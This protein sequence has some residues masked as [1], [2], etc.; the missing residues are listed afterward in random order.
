MTN[1]PQSF[2]E[3]RKKISELPLSPFALKV[4]GLAEDKKARVQ[5]LAEAISR[6][7]EFAARL[8]RIL[9]FAPNWPR[10]LST[11]AQA[12]TVLGSDT[13]KS[14]AFGLSLYPFAPAPQD[15]QHFGADE[16]FLLALRPLW[17][18]SLGCAVVAG[19][20]AAK[21]DHRIQGLAFT[22]G[23]LH[24]LGRVIFY[25]HTRERLFQA[26]E[27]AADKNLPIREAETLVMGAE[28]VEIGELWACKSDLPPMIQRVI[29]YHHEALYTLPSFVGSAERGG[30]AIVQLADLLCE[31]YGI[32]QAG[33]KEEISKE[34]W[35][36]VGIREKECRDL[37]GTVKQEVEAARENFGFQRDAGNSSRSLPH[38]VSTE[39]PRGHVIPFPSRIES[40]GHEKRKSPPKKLTILIV[41]DHNSLCEMLSLYFMRFG[42]HVRTAND[43]ESALAIIAN[44]EIH[45]VLLDLMLPRLDG[46]TVLRQLREA[47]GAKTPYVIVVSAGASE[48]DRNRVLELGA[49]EYMPKPFHLARLIERIQTVEKYLL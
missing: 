44:E 19:R 15:N 5:S 35:S 48:R 18:H 17:E 14:L 26:L 10:R 3:W 40:P 31:A 39:R 41:E 7:P 47:S 9:D 8:L 24:D 28:H 30:I 38:R 45:L 37:L 29:Q 6:E 32:G 12:I 46:F 11:I 43:G 25:G 23:F 4:I 20:I 27:I 1:Q 49:N 21:V 16:D 22:A 42:Y 34:L 36:T 2:G 13:V 33:E